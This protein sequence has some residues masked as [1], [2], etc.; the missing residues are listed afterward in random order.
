MKVL[1]HLWWL[2]L[3]IGMV[4]SL[5]ACGDDKDEK[6][7][8]NDIVTTNSEIV[9][10][11]VENEFAGYQFDSDGTGFGWEADNGSLEDYW[12]LT[13]TYKNG[14]LRWTYDD[15]ETETWV[16]NHVDKSTM[17]VED[18]DYPDEIFTLTKVR[19]FP[20]E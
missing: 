9:G 2:V 7:D 6:D 3:A 4:L 13:W 8:D 15:G 17:I 5:T 11:W 16:V 19:K 18:T 12:D 10:K 14:I 1:K 20:W